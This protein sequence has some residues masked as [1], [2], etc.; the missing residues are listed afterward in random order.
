M[1]KAK[2][3]TTTLSR[4][5]YFFLGFHFIN[6]IV[7][8]IILSTIAFFHFLLDHRLADIQDWVFF[9]GWEVLMIGKIIS[10][11]VIFRFLGI[12]SFERKPLIH[13]LA[14][15]RGFWRKELF[16]CLAFSLAGLII[17][18]SPSREVSY[19]FSLYRLTMNSL[20]VLVFY[21]SEALL[22][23]A[24]NKWLPLK[25]GQFPVEI[26][27]FSLISFI[28]HKNL[29]VFGQGW[30]APV[31]FHFIM[32]FSLLK[33][34]GDF[35]WLHA[36]TWAVVFLVPLSVVFGMDPLWTHQFSPFEFGH[37]I[38]GIE[39]GVFTLLTLFYLKRRKLGGV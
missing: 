30:N 23:L 19:E 31:I 2:F 3:L 13:L 11:V 21:L 26:F 12:L 29:F 4:H 38:T 17:V 37:D 28:V 18:G 6:A 9:H 5:F 35:S 1:V 33:M 27:F 25:R 10:L 15:N 22:V 39:I 34:R 20:G 32:I 36:V 16:I 7:H 8:L 14:F 24:L